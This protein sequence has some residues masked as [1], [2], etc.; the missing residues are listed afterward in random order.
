SAP[1]WHAS[2]P[3]FSA[4][5]YTPEPLAP[6][7]TWPKLSRSPSTSPNTNTLNVGEVC[8]EKQMLRCARHDKHGS[9]PG[10]EISPVGRNDGRVADGAKSWAKAQ[11]LQG[12]RM[13]AGAVEG[14]L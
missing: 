3:Q 7:H 13:R 10:R 1:L 14:E 6:S 12:R 5:M 9:E 8:G 4:A 11:P 2:S